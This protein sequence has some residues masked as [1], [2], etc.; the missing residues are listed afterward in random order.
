MNNNKNFHEKLLNY[1]INILYSLDLK[2]IQIE[3]IKK[4]LSNHLE[5]IF[6]K[7][8]FKDKANTIEKIVYLDGNL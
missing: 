4:E 7:I 6:K 8:Y 5:E 1:V 2:N 3:E